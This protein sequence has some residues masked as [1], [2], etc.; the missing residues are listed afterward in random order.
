MHFFCRFI[1]GPGTFG[2]YYTG[3]GYMLILNIYVA[4]LTDNFPIATAA[5]SLAFPGA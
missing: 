5:R 1:P 2:L 3:F 4:C